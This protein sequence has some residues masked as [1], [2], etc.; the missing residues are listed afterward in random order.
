MKQF[1]RSDIKYIQ[2]RA[3]ERIIE[4]FD[5]LGVEY[6]ERHDYIQ[7]ACPIHDGDNQRAL[8]WAM[9][10]YHWKCT[11]RHCQEETI[12]GPSNSVFGL[13]RGA[14]STNTNTQW[15]FQQAV[16][17]VAK[18]LNLHNTKFDQETAEDIAINNAIRKYRKRR[19]N[20]FKQDGILLSD[21][22][23]K[24]KPDSVYYPKRGI[25]IDTINKYHISFCNAKDKPFYQRAFFPV[26]DETG[27]YVVGWSGR[28]IFE[29]CAKCGTHHPPEMQCPDN[30]HC[31]LYTKWKHSQGFRSEH[32]LYNYWYAKPFIAKT[33]SAIVC[34]SPGNCWAF[35]AVGIRNSVCMFGLSLSNEQRKLL[36]RAGAVTVIFVLDNDDAGRQAIERLKKE[37]VT[38][39]R[40]FFVTPEEA[41][42]I[43]DMS[44]DDIRSQIMPVLQKAS[45]E[46]ILSDR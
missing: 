20:Q 24:L 6:T 1:T 2:E 17:F 27:R 44:P 32:C 40:L 29:K 5:A 3:G 39:F 38:Y 37:W 46:G 28:S 13:V 34:E 11:T 21:V 14:M 26:L 19:R 7:C 22:L 10:T 35:D 23:S 42:D 16:G 25:S 30:D 15:T 33:G 41:N 9:Q 36:Q 12:T 4:I 8:Y 18:V 45:R 43:G 31:R